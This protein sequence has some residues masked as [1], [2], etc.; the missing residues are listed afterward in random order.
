M[1]K[2]S[3]H[4]QEKLATCHP[5]LITLFSHVIDIVDCTIICG[6]R[7]LNEQE[8]AFRLGQSKLHYPDSKH[9]SLPSKAVDAALYPIDWNNKVGFYYFAGI[10]RGVAD[11]LAIKIRWGGDWDG[12][13]DLKDQ[14]FFDLPHFELI[15]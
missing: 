8:E 11:R 9:N 14:T 10:V 6:Y 12:D 3:K 1:R 2:F 5:D 13:A 4:S 7:G 15:D